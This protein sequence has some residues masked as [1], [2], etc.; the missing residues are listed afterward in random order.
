MKNILSEV[1][2]VKSGSW[3]SRLSVLL[4]LGIASLSVN[5]QALQGSFDTKFKIY[6]KG[7]AFSGASVSDWTDIGWK[8]DRLYKQIV[9]W[10]SG[11]VSNITYEVSDL[12]VGSNTIL[13]ENVKLRFVNY[14]KGDLVSLGC[15]GYANRDPNSYEELGD[16]LSDIPIT[17]LSSY[18]PLKIWATID[19]PSN[20]QPGTYSGTV[21]VKVSGTIALTFTLNMEVVDKVLPDVASWDFHLDLWQYPTK[22][23]DRYNQANPSNTFNYWS[24]EHFTLLKPMYKLLAS[25]GQKVITAHIKEGALGSA[26]MVKWIKNTDGTWE[27]D[28]TNFDRYVDSLMSWGIVK[29]INCQSLVGW[30]SSVIPYWDESSSSQQN[31]SAAVGST[32]YNT[33]WDHFLTSFKTHLDSKGWFSKTVLY[34]D[35]VGSTLMSQVINTV[36]SN[37][38]GWKIGLAANS[39]ITSG[40]DG[41]IYDMCTKYSLNYSLDRGNKISTFY[42]CCNPSRPNNFITSNA[43]PADN[44][45]MGWR[46]QKKNYNG[47]LRW[48]YDLWTLQDVTDM[49]MGSQTS[50]DYAFMYRSSNNYNM[51]FYSSVR[52]E[53]LRDGIQDHEKVQILL[54]EL[55]AS[56][57]PDDQIALNA[58]NNKINEFSFGSADTNP[59][60]LVE[61]A[62][63]MVKDIV[64]GNLVVDTYCSVGGDGYGNYHVSSLSTTGGSTN[65]SFSTSSYPSGGYEH[66]TATCD[67]VEQ[68]SSFTVN[69]TNG[70]TSGGCS[71]VKMWI[72]WNRDGDFS[73]PGEEVYANGAAGSCGNLTNHSVN[74]SVPATATAGLTRIRIKFRDAWR[75]QPLACG[76]ET[77]AGAADFNLEITSGSADTQAPSAPTNLASLN[78]TETSVDLSW[79]ASTDNVGVTGYDVFEG[80][81]VTQTVTG[82]TATITGLT[83]STAYSFTVKAKDAAGNVSSASNTVNVTTS[84]ASSQSYCSTGG[85]SGNYHVG[86]LST[87]GGST[88]ISFSTSSY[89]SGGY[90]HHTVTNITAEPG[91]SFAVNFTNGSSSGGCS[92]VIMWIDWNRDGDFSDTGEQIYA[93]GAA[94]SCGN[95]TSH[96]V[97]VSVPATA[98]AGLTRIRI[99]FRDAWRDQPLACGIETYAGAADFNLEITSGSADTQAPSA[100]TNLAS[101]NITETSVDLSWTA[102]TDNVGV[103]GYDV[104]EGGVVTQTVTGTT[105]T[106]T[107]LTA[108]TAYSFTVKAKDAAGNVSSASNTV[109]VTTSAASSQS[110]CSTGGSSG[111]YH[112]GSLSTTG[113]STNIS[114]STSSYPSGGYEHHTAT[115]I[116]V[117]PGNSFTVNF[118]NGSGYGGCSRVKMWI[119]WNRDGDFSDTGEQIYANGSASSCGNLTSHSVNVPVPATATIG[120]TRIRIK[121]RDAWLNQPLACG[122]ETYAGA[123]DFDLNISQLKSAKLNVKEDLKRSVKLFPNPVRQKLSV[124]IVSESNIEFIKMYSMNGQLMINR[125]VNTPVFK[126]NLDL[127]HLISGQYILTIKIDGQLISEKII[128]KK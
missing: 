20:A 64:T 45:W 92:R 30:N 107:G 14:A 103:T 8:G 101:L 11:S 36:K 33:R 100:P 81:V 59:I 47:F 126:G 87:T 90:E 10:S 16:I 44:T 114:F 2:M 71:R 40:I 55:S 86:S 13:S 75:D 121:F 26:S 80:G 115:N 82:T 27:Y 94:G 109:N 18:D 22:V 106:I 56:S 99:K 4:I 32:T 19:I 84:A 17:S 119:D 52:L 89:P 9:L 67:T 61:S 37:N 62:Q 117:E 41:D 53:L 111:N 25:M 72:D 78:I 60:V 127:S 50:G 5:A 124:D 12:T 76:I 29:Q 83:A 66:H 7:E 125:K 122:V 79:T 105:A 85:S 63:Q 46:A 43:S 48:A 58:L 38:S 69:F 21:K 98:T 96:S 68:G 108:S 35:E 23:L 65:I 57:D 95:L 91:N 88:N 123:A 3:I 15:S 128:V 70:S 6:K 102:S 113:G 120:S 24:T 110:Y 112:V 49:R 73:D 42:V 51:D 118:T 77:Y 104:F 1:L 28:F 54:S 34:M 97:N 39:I 31:L 74:V 116:T 93:N